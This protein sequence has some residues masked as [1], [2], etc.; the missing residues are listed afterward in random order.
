MKTTFADFEYTGGAIVTG[1]A[2]PK[3]EQ[4]FFVLLSDWTWWAWSATAVL[5]LIGLIGFPIAF[6]A[7]AGLTGIQAIV[8]VIRERS[9]RAFAA[10]IRLAYGILLGICALPGMGWLYW[11]PMVWTFALV[12]FGYCLMARML[13][14]LPWNRREPLSLEMLLRTFTSRP[15]LARFATGNRSAGCAGGLCT[16]DAQVRNKAM[17]GNLGNLRNS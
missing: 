7:A 15:S 1:P 14:L 3:R 8:M 12:I 11:V 16:I 4:L 2:S 10:Q 9:W 13:S 5:L 6:A 17:N